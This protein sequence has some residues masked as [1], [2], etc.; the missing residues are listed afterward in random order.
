MPC[1]LCGAWV[2][3][4]SW[5]ESSTL[6]NLGVQP[7]R[8]GA[9]GAAWFCLCPMCQAL[10]D[11]E[12]LVHR[13]PGDRQAVEYVTAHLVALRAWMIERIERQAWQ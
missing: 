11:L 1:A 13:L 6:R 5:C 7:G 4:P 9:D 8:R 2:A 3:R 12:A 10:L